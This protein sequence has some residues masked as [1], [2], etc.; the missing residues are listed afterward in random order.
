MLKLGEGLALA[1][2]VLAF[3]SRR[4]GEFGQG[5]QADK[6]DSFGKT[7]RSKVI[8]HNYRVWGS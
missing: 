7:E 2:V 5:G 6:D 8:T 4:S 1:E 3:S